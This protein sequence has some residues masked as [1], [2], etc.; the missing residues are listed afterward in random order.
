MPSK[1][2]ACKVSCQMP[3]SLVIRSFMLLEVKAKVQD[4][5]LFF[6]TRSLC[7][8][9][10]GLKV[11]CDLFT[12]SLMFLKN[13]SSFYVIS[14]NSI[15]YWVPEISSITAISYAPAQLFEHFIG[16]QFC[17]SHNNFVASQVICPTSCHI[18]PLCLIHFGWFSG[19]LVYSAALQ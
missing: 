17:S 5:P 4:M 11:Q 14:K 6:S 10:V 15:D 8:H 19:V 13:C 16:Y 1:S 7:L 9:K 2:T 3:V 12:Q 18:H